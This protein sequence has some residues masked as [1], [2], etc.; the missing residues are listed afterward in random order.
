MDINIVTVIIEDFFK[1]GAFLCLYF[2]VLLLSKWFKDLFTPYK[3]GEELTKKDN[4]AVALMMCGYYFAVTFIFIGSFFG[5]SYGLQKDLILVGQYSFIGIVLL[6]LSRFFNDRI[7]L[8]KFCNIHHIIKEHNLAVAS[9]QLGSYLATGLIAAGAVVGEGGGVVTF[10]SFFVLGQ[11]SLF[12][13]SIIYE[14]F[15]EYNLHEE[16]EKKNISAGVAFGG[17]LVALGIIITNGVSRDF[18]SWKENLIIAFSMNIFAFVFLPIVRI[19]MD[20]LVIPGDKLSREIKEDKNLGAGLLE[21]TIAISFALI[22]N[23]VI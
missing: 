2:I 12:L 5:P 1:A 10:I 6:N 4:V 18:I 7:I 23:I 19:I 16:L 21:A 14:F 22:L 20:K 9:V 8:R 13:F 17:T 11:L 3:I 15:T